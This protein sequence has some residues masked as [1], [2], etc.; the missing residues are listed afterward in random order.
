MDWSGTPG[1][2]GLVPEA[3]AMLKA[4][5]VC[6]RDR[7]DTSYERPFTIDQQRIDKPP[8]GIPGF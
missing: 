2:T 8:Q 5:G 6:S 3:L 7:N 4:V 1:D